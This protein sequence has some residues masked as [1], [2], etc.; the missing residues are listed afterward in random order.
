[1]NSS[2]LLLKK[3]KSNTPEVAVG[4]ESGCVYDYQGAMTLISS[5]VTIS[6][7]I[8]PVLRAVCTQ[9]GRLQTPSPPTFMTD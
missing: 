1:M 7:I 2:L 4:N 6:H 5:H 3:K 9:A 8:V